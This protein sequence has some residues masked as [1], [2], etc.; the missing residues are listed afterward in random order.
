MDS[1]SIAPELT[2]F[3]P[4]LSPNVPYITPRLKSPRQV[5]VRNPLVG[6]QGASVLLRK[7]PESLRKPPESLRSPPR[8]GSNAAR[9]ETCEAGT[10]RWSVSPS[11]IRC[12]PERILI[13]YGCLPSRDRGDGTAGLSTPRR[14]LAHNP[15]LPLSTRARTPPRRTRYGSCAVSHVVSSARGCC[16]LRNTRRDASPAPFARQWAAAPRKWRPRSRLSRRR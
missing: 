15:R 16:A 5:I 3:G 10:P 12:P 2:V 13:L 14:P 7:P 1:G 8:G 6:S 9:L 11:T 4:P